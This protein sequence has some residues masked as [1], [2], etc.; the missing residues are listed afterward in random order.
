MNTP[1]ECIW[2]KNLLS[3]NHAILPQPTEAYIMSIK[4]WHMEI[5]SLI[6]QCQT[7]TKYRVKTYSKCAQENMSDSFCFLKLPN[8]N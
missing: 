4:R 7:V 2:T 6:V 8:S 5:K 3:A 1:T